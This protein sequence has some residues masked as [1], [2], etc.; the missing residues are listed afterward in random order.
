MYK[1]LTYQQHLGS[2]T[3]PTAAE[4]PKEN[5]LSIVLTSAGGKK[6][7]C[8]VAAT[9]AAPESAGRAPAGHLQTPNTM[10]AT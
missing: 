8:G 6:A 9:S 4:K 10:N 7:E 3:A 2:E 5:G 1:Q